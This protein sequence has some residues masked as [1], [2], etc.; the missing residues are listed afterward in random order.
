[1]HERA[2]EAGC[3][4]S[5]FIRECG[6]SG[7]VS[8]VPSINREQWAQ[9]AGTTA[10]LNQLVRP[11][12]KGTVPQTLDVT[13]LETSRLLHEVRSRLI[14]EIRPSCLQSNSAYGGGCTTKASGESSGSGSF[15]ASSS[16]AAP[17]GSL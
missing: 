2:R 7:K 17:S 3:R 5:G 13:L 16:T 6:I 14:G 15:P 1:M 10:N 12:H 9:L 8:P 4:L 11:C